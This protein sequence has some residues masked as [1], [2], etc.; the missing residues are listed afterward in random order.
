MAFLRKKKKVWWRGFLLTHIPIIVLGIIWFP[1]FK[2]QSERGSWLL[3]T[4]PAWKS[5]A[6]GA[7]LKQVILV[8]MKFTLGRITFAN[9]ISYY[10]LAIV[11]SIP[12]LLVFSKTL[13]FKKTERTILFWLFLPLLL[14]FASSIF[15]PI[16]I[17]FR[18]LYVVPAFYLFVSWGALQI[19][20]KKLRILTIL[21]L[22]SVNLVGWV[23]YVSQDQQQREQWREVTSFVEQNAVETDI[24]IFE[25]PE[26]FAPYR[27][28]MEGK[29]AAVGVTDSISADPV[30]TSQKTKEVVSGK[31]GVFY[32]EYLRDLSDPHRA[33][34]KTLQDEGFKVD[35]IYSGFQG[36]GQIYYWSKI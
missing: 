17:Y 24:V 21:A 13:L 34:E 25:Y 3:T 1:Y 10:I 6:G 4:L 28:Y 29:V 36:V 23:I 30:K 12:F 9:K 5:L 19:K 32:F 27:W 2:L 8:W 7:N 15:V 26:P 11:A 18:F 31:T 20:N 35:K 14:G 16:F 33:V 22:L